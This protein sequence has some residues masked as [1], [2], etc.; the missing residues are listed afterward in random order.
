MV[1]DAESEILGVKKTDPDMDVS[2]RNF[3][4]STVGDELALATGRQS[5]TVSL[6]TKG[7]GGILLGGRLGKS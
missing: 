1:F 5:R 7:R 4:G 2:P 3:I 6:A